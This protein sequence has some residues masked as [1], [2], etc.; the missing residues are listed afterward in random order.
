[1]EFKL[2]NAFKFYQNLEHQDQ[3]IDELEQWFKDNHPEKL[4]QFHQ[5]LLN[6]PSPDLA[7]EAMEKLT[8]KSS[9]PLALATY[10]S[11]SEI[12]LND[13]IVA[14]GDLTWA[15]AIPNGDR[16]LPENLEV[17]ENIV[18]LAKQ[19][20]VARDQIGKPFLIT[21][22]YHHKPFGAKV[23]GASKNQPMTGGAVDFRVEGYTGR[24]LAKMLDWWEGGLATYMYVPYM[25]HLDMGPQRRWQ[26]QYPG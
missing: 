10:S 12:H 4:E 16:H 13:P 25:L 23:H 22:W 3:A 5:A 15:D 6:G 11:S 17:V 24:Q 8:F 9:Q 21:S 18:A 14:G 1:M 2:R 20:Q 19:L 26:A 7:P